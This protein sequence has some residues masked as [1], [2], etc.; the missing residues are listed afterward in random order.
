MKAN[1]AVTKLAK[2]LLRERITF[3]AAAGELGIAPASFSR[4]MGGKQTP[5]EP[6]Q[7]KIEERWGVES[8]L[9]PKRLPAETRL[10]Q[11]S[12]AL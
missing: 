10:R 7:K 8:T 6:L 3:K 12:G 5:R 11:L 1:P 9:W 2:A 4:I